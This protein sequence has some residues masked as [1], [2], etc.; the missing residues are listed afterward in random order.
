MPPPQAAQA[1]PGAVWTAL[2]LICATIT[3]L[4]GAF[5]AF[6]MYMRPVLKVCYMLHLHCIHFAYRERARLPWLHCTQQSGHWHFA[7]E[8]FA[9]MQPD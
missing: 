7:E 4:A 3:A 2:I 5:T 9:H 8:H 1:Q 6:M